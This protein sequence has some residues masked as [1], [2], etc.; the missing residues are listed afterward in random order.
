MRRPAG[1]LGTYLKA[2]FTHHWNLLAFFGALGFSLLSGMPDVLI[3]LVVAGEMVYVGGLAAHPKFQAYIDAQAAKAVRQDGSSRSQQMLNTMLRRLPPRTIDRFETLRNRCLELR[4]LALELKDPGHTGG[5]RPL[6]DMQM[7][8]LDRLL[9]IYL[10]LLFTEH[11]LERFQERTHPSQVEAD[12]EAL[13]AQLSDSASIADDIQRQKV[14]RTL[15]DNLQTCRDRLANL[16]KAR[17]NLTVVKLELDRL[18]NKIRALSELPL[19]RQEPDYI[20]AQVDAVASSMVQT[21]QTMNELQF[22]TGLE[23]ADEAVPPLMSRPVAM[24][25]E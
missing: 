14:Q 18:E 23:T 2:A 22:A 1:K 16:Q 5:A 24:M 20:T 3:P 19:N 12:I 4:Q 8:G 6:D 9:W 15:Q 21:E 10:R 11:S 17:D 25:Q 13:E 7:S